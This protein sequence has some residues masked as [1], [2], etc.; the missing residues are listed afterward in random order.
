[1]GRPLKPLI[2]FNKVIQIA[3][4]LVEKNGPDGLN[5][6]A[7]GKELGVNPASLYHHF[8]D[9]NEI[10]DAVADHV[11]RSAKLPKKKTIATWDDIAIDL[12]TAYRSLIVAQPNVTLLVVGR[13]AGHRPAVAHQN[14]EELLSKLCDAGF[15]PERA[16]LAMI[17]LE[18]LATG[19]AIEE[20]T[21]GPETQFAPVD[22]NKYPILYKISQGPKLQ[23]RSA[24][25]EMCYLMMLGLKVDQDQTALRSKSMSRRQSAVTEIANPAKSRVQSR[26]SAKA[27]SKRKKT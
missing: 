20:A 19:S 14:Y 13:R 21:M 10:L 6:R 15:P 27:D 4:K 12:A 2:E 23:L 7:L 9:K 18:M 3:L 26:R 5:M 16:L 1:M 8:K 25:K 11:M 24:F 22:P 17:S